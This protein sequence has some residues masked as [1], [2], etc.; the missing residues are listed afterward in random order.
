MAGDIQSSSRLA[1]GLSNAGSVVGSVLLAISLLAVLGV[2]YPLK[3][4]P[5][6]FF[7]FAW[8]FIWFLG[9]GLPASLTQQLSP[10]AEQTLISV[11]V[12]VV[13]VPVVI[14]WGYVFNQYV[15]A[16]GD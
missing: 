12:G 2:R 7:E 10:E 14:P 9:W 3:M 8:K 11:L 15:K 5:V 1:P 16:P 4:L 6:L 13:L